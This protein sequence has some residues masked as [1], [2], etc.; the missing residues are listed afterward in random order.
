M[1]QDTG[2]VTGVIILVLEFRETEEYENLLID[3]QMNFFYNLD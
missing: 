2:M 3:S 1:W